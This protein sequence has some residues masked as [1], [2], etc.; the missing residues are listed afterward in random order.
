MFGQGVGDKGIRELKYFLRI[1]VAHSRQGIFISQQKYVIDLL[2]ETGKI[3]CKLAS[4]PI[5]PN[6]RR[7]KA[8]EDIAV[9]GETYQWLVGRLI[10]LSHTQPDMAYAVSLISQFIHST[11]EVHLQAT[12]RVLQYFKGTPGKGIM[13]RRNLRLVLET[14]TDADYAGSMVDRRPTSGYCI[15]LGGNLLSWRSTKQNEIAT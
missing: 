13:Y 5:N 4:T 14:F 8:K 10:Y 15:F 6:L 9:D 11:K 1:E 7:G 2:K 3:A 12:Y